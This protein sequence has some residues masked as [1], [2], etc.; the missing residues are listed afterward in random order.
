MQII[1]TH[2][3][4]L[5][6][7][8]GGEHNGE[9]G[10]ASRSPFAEQRSWQKGTEEAKQRGKNYGGPIPCIILTRVGKLTF[11]KPQGN[12]SCSLEWG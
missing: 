6:F 2:Y 3:K 4:N 5:S 11:S 12:A 8:S 10:I 1:K 7:E 9:R